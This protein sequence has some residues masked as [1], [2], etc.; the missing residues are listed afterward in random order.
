MIDLLSPF[1]PWPRVFLLGESTAFEGKGGKTE[2]DRARWVLIGPREATL[3]DR[4][5][6]GEDVGFL[7]GNTC[8]LEPLGGLKL[9]ITLMKAQGPG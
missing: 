8:V 3:R 4:D 6:P 5:V 7:L 2:R 1:Y 9:L